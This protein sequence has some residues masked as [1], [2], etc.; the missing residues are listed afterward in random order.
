[1]KIPED[2]EIAP[3]KLSSYLLVWRPADDKSGFLARAG[4]TLANPDDLLAALRGLAEKS[5][6]VEDGMNPFGTFFRVDGPIVGPNG[7][8]LSVATVWVRSFDDGSFHFVTLKP[9][10]SPRS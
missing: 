10:R 6:A 9:L 1:M 5:E 4:F 2:A 7:Q 8:A 3:A